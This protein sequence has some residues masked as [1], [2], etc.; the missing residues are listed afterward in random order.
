MGSSSALIV[1]RGMRIAS[2]FFSDYLY[3]AVSMV[4]KQMTQDVQ[5]GE[6]START[7]ISSSSLPD[8]CHL[9]TSARRVATPA[10]SGSDRPR[11]MAARRR[12]SPSALAGGVHRLGDA[13]GVKACG[14]ASRM[15]KILCYADTMRRLDSSG[16]Q[17]RLPTV[18]TSSVGTRRIGR[19]KSRMDDLFGSMATAC[20]LEK[21]RG[22][23]GAGCAGSALR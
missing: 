10:W 19:E 16:E 15:I 17:G 22:K 5:F 23:T 13:V 11:P 12:A 21:K 3:V 8:P 6:T 20:R 18:T 14:G 9:A 1:T 2:E 4:R 7:E